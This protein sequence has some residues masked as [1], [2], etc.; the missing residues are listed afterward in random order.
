MT[1]SLG[2][3]KGGSGAQA[4]AFKSAEI[5]ATGITEANVYMGLSPKRVAEKIK[6]FRHTLPFT[7]F[8]VKG[9]PGNRKSIE[10]AMG[11]A[12]RKRGSPPIRSRVNCDYSFTGPQGF[13][14]IVTLAIDDDPAEIAQ[15]ILET[16]ED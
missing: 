11:A 12:R 7:V 9:V 14:R 16:M 6:S 15:C 3:T 4:G 5:S 8:D 10:A 13:E 1:A 2:K